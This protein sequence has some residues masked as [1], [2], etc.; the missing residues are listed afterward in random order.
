MRPS[1]RSPLQEIFSKMGRFC[2]TF[3]SNKCFMPRSI[4]FFSFLSFVMV[5]LFTIAAT[6]ALLQYSVQ[7]LNIGEVDPKTIENS[8]DSDL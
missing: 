4:F 7:A 3:L 1:R 5:R 2:I 6:V 8:K